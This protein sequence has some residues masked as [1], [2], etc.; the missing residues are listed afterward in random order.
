MT[1]ANTWLLDGDQN[2]L[3]PSSV[4]ADLQAINP[5]LGLNYHIAMNVFMVT[6][7]WPEHDPRRE[8]IQRGEMAPDADFEILCPVPVNVSLDELT[9]WV[10]GQLVRVGATRED[11]RRMVTENEERAKK[12]NAD[13]LAKAKEDTKEELM[14]AVTNPAPKVGR[15]RTRVKV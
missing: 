14:K 12:A 2:P 4:V 15:R 9:E 1:R 5:R 11:V 13:V 7:K 6:M 3:A 8:M 10:R